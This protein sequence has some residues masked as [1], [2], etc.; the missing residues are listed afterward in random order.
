MANGG[1]GE[2]R[3]SGAAAPRASL[4]VITGM[5]RSGTSALA[6]SCNLLGVDLGDDFIPTQPDNQSGFWE[7]AGVK[8]ADD[9]VLASHGMLWDDVGA[10]PRPWRDGFGG[11][12]ARERLRATLA[13]LVARGPL[14]GVKD[15]RISRLLPVWLPLLDALDVSCAFLIALRE[16][17]EVARSLA[18]R[19]G[20]SEPRALLL[21]L[22]YSLEAERD[23]RGRRRAFVV[24]DDLLADWRTTLERVAREAAVVWP[25]SFD[26][27]AVELGRFLDPSLKHHAAP[28][29]LGKTPEDALAR[30]ACDAF[31]ALRA[32]RD[33]ETA[34]RHAELDRLH[35]ALDA[36]DLVFGPLLRELESRAA[37]SRGVVAPSSAKPATD[38]EGDGAA[39][40]RSQEEREL[41]RARREAMLAHELALE[42]ERELA[43]TIERFAQERTALEAH[44]AAVEAAGVASAERIAILDNEVAVLRRET[45][46]LR[47]A[48][49][50]ALAV[51]ADVERS[52]SWR[53][54]SPL[55]ALTAAARGRQ[56]T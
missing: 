18:R 40:L 56:R 4:I 27:A 15:P 21:W 20:L 16:P 17:R 33:G 48:R 22:R 13:V 41:D 2:G 23:T 9:A 50:A 53:V 44:I 26:G 28:A 38:G 7:D 49:D 8:D 24:F 39:M 42:R 35:A 37:P 19:E 6:R 14:C 47:E 46:A 55:R 30:L 5:H 34:A 45:E 51:I 12:A 29:A 25:V 54:T 3:P 31:V 36:A 1:T 43:A 32:L 52:V 10:L 11:A